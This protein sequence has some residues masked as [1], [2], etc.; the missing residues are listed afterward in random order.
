[1][2][3]LKIRLIRVNGPSLNHCLRDNDTKVLSDS[4]AS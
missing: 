4:S 1:M 3:P 2:S